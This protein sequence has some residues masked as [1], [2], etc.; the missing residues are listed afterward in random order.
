MDELVANIGRDETNRSFAIEQ[1]PGAG[2]TRRLVCQ[3]A[4][5]SGQIAAL[6]S[7]RLKRCH[8]ASYFLKTF[9]R[10]VFCL[11][12]A[13]VGHVRALLA[14][15]R[16]SLQLSIY[17]R[18]ALGQRIMNIAGYSGA[19]C[20]RPGFLSFVKMFGQPKCR[21]RVVLQIIHQSRIGESANVARPI[22]AKPFPNLRCSAKF[23]SHEESLFF[24]EQLLFCF[25][26][27]GQLFFTDLWIFQAKRL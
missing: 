22:L 26:Q 9:V 18:K 24:V 1:H 19:L 3:F 25:L 27:L 5:I 10:Q 23:A 13:R 20:Q 14:Y 12:N 15:L 2:I 21:R 11:E 8:Q 6:S 16:R 4:Q 7:I 17:S